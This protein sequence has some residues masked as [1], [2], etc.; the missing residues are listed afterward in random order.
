MTET[1]LEEA[2]RLVSTDRGTAYGHPADDFAR[3]ARIWSVILGV[4]V[5]AVQVGLCQIGT[6]LA[7]EVN[8]RRR[9]NLV[10]VA[11]YARC[12][13]LVYERQSEAAATVPPRTRVEYVDDILASFKL[14]KQ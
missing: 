4:E 14:A 9:D 6:K 13:E 8:S 2:S 10:D 1:V 12:V 5:T 11:G 3:A 7:R